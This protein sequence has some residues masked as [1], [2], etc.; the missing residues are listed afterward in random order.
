MYK[1]NQQIFFVWVNLC[2]IKELQYLNE[3]TK[4]EIKSQHDVKLVN[5]ISLEP[6]KLGTK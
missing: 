4:R 6:Q 5:C 1:R 2:Y 3:V